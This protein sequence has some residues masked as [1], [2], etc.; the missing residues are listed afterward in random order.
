MAV[1]S[2]L[3]RLSPDDREVLQLFAFNALR[4]AAIHT[5]NIS[6][7]PSRVTMWIQL[8]EMDGDVAI[9]LKTRTPVPALP[10]QRLWEEPLRES[11]IERLEGLDVRTSV[12]LR[13]QIVRVEAVHPGQHLGVPLIRQ[14][15]VGAVTVP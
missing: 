2:I 15:L 12:T 13:I 11:A 4:S 14:V 10:V 7:P 5:A 1:H 6:R 9:R 3:D 8:L